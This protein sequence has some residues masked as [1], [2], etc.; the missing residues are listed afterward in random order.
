MSG[1]DPSRPQVPDVTAA[2][3]PT[4]PACHVP[5]YVPSCLLPEVRPG[6]TL[7]RHAG[8]GPRAASLALRRHPD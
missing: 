7:G 8:P 2:E 1:P 5:V 3:L 6:N 4:G